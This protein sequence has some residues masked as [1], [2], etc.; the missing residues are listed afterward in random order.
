MKIC[1]W[2]VNSI[3]QRVH[4]EH[5]VL[6]PWLKE[7]QPDV[8]C[9]QEVM[10]TE[11]QF[12]HW[13]VERAGYRALTALEKGKNGVAML[14]RL[15]AP[16]PELLAKGWPGRLDQAGLG[17]AR[18]PDA[19]FLAARAKGV[20]IACVYVPF[21]RTPDDPQWA[22]KLRF[23]RDLA[24]WAEAII[25][26]G[27]GLL[28]AGDINVTPGADDASSVYTLRA[29]GHPSPET[30]WPAWCHAD[31]RAALQNVM[32]Q[33]LTD[34]GA[35]ASERP[36]TFTMWADRDFG[37]DTPFGVRIDLILASPTMHARYVSSQTHSAMR[38]V[39][40]ASDHV[41]VEATFKDISRMYGALS[42]S[43]LY[44]LETEASDTDIVGLILPDPAALLL[45]L[46][47][48]AEHVQRHKNVGE[49][50]AANDVDL[51]F[52]PPTAFVR[53]LMLG[54]PRAWEL[55]FAPDACLTPD[56]TAVGRRF[57]A[58]LRHNA[59]DLWPSRP[60]SVIAFAN[61]NISVFQRKAAKTTKSAED[62]PQSFA[63]SAVG[64]HGKLLSHAL[65]VLQQA[66]QMRRE[67]QMT[68]PRPNRDALMAIKLGHAPLAQTLASIDG[69]RQELVGHTQ[70]LPVEEPS[71]NSLGYTFV[72]ELLEGQLMQHRWAARPPRYRQPAQSL[73]W[74]P[75]SLEGLDLALGDAGV[76]TDI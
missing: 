48:K 50:N 26:S 71:A 44:G 10:C 11:R 14:T 34:V 74:V 32:A 56:T 46:Q 59:Q 41:P 18:P 5:D 16:Q 17:H 54:Q 30:L 27:Q 66:L 65:R 19:R 64:E 73:G 58:K 9:L 15:D 76:S 28:I 61:R 8:V 12:P 57:M 31:M 67:G 63:D 49:K 2:N 6:G 33:T 29:A 62:S 68:F 47:D 70:I 53:E 40:K 75:R 38:T 72:R 69:A 35:Q 23:L 52:W 37:R 4:P 45:G 60:H 22:H 1:S 3:R 39:H 25:T 43:R 36:R 21:G 7:H 55:L 51:N 13:A 42:G 24:A 20:V